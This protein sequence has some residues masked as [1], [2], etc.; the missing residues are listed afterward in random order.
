MSTLAGLAV[1]GSGDTCS[2]SSNTTPTPS[3][4]LYRPTGLAIDISNN[5][6]IAD[7]KHNCV[8]MLANEAPASPLSPPS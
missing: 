1:S 2:T 6:H 4:G 7:S 3:Q 5:L 8:R